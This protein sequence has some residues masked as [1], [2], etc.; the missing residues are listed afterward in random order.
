MNIGAEAASPDRSY[1]WRGAQQLDFWQRLRSTQHQQAGFSLRG[2]ALVEHRK[3]LR[4]GAADVGRGDPGQYWLA[5][6]SRQQT[7]ATHDYTLH[8][9]ACFEFGFQT[10]LLRGQL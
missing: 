4:D 6:G 1:A 8:A 10:G 7:L 2:H 9:Q 5:A 3:E